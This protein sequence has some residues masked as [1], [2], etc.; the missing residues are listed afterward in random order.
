MNFRNDKLDGFLSELNGKKIILVGAGAI[1]KEFVKTLDVTLR[2]ELRK[3]LSKSV[4]GGFVRRYELAGMEELIEFCVDNDIRRHNTV[5]DIDNNRFMVYSMQKLEELASM[6]KQYTIV[7]TSRYFVEIF[8]QLSHIKC[9][10]NVDCY[11]APIMLEDNPN[12]FWNNLFTDKIYR[13]NILNYKSNLKH[14]KNVHKGERCFIIGNGPSLKIEDLE[15]LKNEITFA[16]NRI[17]LLFERTDWRPTYYCVIDNKHLD[18]STDDIRSVK[19]VNK[20]I[21]LCILHDQKKDIEDATYF[22]FDITGFYPKPPQFSEDISD[23]IVNGMTVTYI[24]IQIA[25]YMG[26]KEIYLLGL[27]HSFS[28][29]LLPD[30]SL[31]INDGVINYFQSDYTKNNDTP[32]RIQHMELAYMQAR[33]YCELNKIKICNATRGGKLEIFE[34][35]DFDNLF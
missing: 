31:K 11:I 17:Y 5:F 1:A 9:L 23:K 27:D 2:A 29:E 7:I 20:F 28:R 35:V 34:R 30:G 24:L 18:N 33:M 16:V 8:I 10:E 32:A 3:E 6:E 22:D 21:P 14:Q 12:P 25:A 26:F 13:D 4:F 15:M 19:A